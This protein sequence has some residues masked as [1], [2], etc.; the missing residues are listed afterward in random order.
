MCFLPCESWGASSYLCAAPYLEL[1]LGSSHTCVANAAIPEGARLSNRLD[2][3]NFRA[4]RMTLDERGYRNGP[5]LRVDKP[6]AML[7]GSSFSLGMALND[8]ETFSAQLN[9]QL[10]PVVYNAATV[11]HAGL[12]SAKVSSI[13][14]ESGMNRGLIVFEV[15][16][17]EPLSYTEPPPVKASGRVAS[18]ID[19]LRAIPEGLAGRLSLLVSLK[20][21]IEFPS[22]LM[23]VSTLVNM[24][25]HSGRVLPNP[26]YD[27]YSEEQLVTGR[28]VLMY[29]KDKQF[30]QNPAN[31]SVTADAIRRFRDGL[32]GRGYRLAV[33]LLPN[34]YS[35]YY[36]LLR[37]H[38]ELDS[39][40]DYIPIL[41]QA[42]R[43]ELQEGRAIYYPDDAHWNGL[44]C[45]IAARATAPWLRP[46]L[47][48]GVGSGE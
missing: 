13:A 43:G 15:L 1:H 20:R 25:I 47:A 34:A 36:P 11:L 5:D 45:E 9:R 27:A 16:N 8:D 23:R 28:N 6:K 29:S 39:S 46:M 35:V 3:L 32:A 48:E 12:S 21:R 41:R 18:V 40:E 17:R 44:G 30:S 31:A 33:V 10:G 24:R 7:V 19:R 38:G 37:N 26:F 14:R 4:E 2:F 22:A 42:A